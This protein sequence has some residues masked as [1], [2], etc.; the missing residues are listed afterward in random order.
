MENNHSAPSSDSRSP[1]FSFVIII[2]FAL[3]GLFIGIFAGQ[4]TVLPFYD[5]DIN[6]AMNFLAN[7]IG[8]ET[9]RTPLL[10]VQGVTSLFAFIL[11]PLLYLYYYERKSRGKYLSTASPLWPALL[12]TVLIS[13]AFMFVNSPI[14]EWNMNIDFPD[15]MSS[16][17][18]YA[19]QQEQYLMKITKYV[20][21][22]DSLPQ[23]VLGLIVIAVIP[24]IGEE[25]LFRGLIQDKLIAIFRNP[26]AGIWVAGFLFGLFHFQFYGLVPRMLLGVLFGYLYWWSGSLML[27]IVAHL[28][29]NGFT[30]IMVYLYQQDLVGFDIEGTSEISSTTVAVFGLFF[31]L[32]LYYFFKVIKHQ[33][34]A[35]E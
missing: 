1:L 3:V 9:G 17:E 21:Q 26:H 32:L 23:L 5:F 35:N 24:G 15:F 4:V 34:L 22:F 14:I 20:T 12:L 29:N 30:L 33:S 13:Q 16:F 11:A 6:K 25:L 27:A 28:F 7:P 8:D 18:S 2:V 10:L 19:Q 31:G